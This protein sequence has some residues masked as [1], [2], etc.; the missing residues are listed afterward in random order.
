MTTQ[1]LD[2]QAICLEEVYLYAR[3]VAYSFNLSKEQVEDHVQ[4][5]VIKVYEKIG[6]LKD[7]SKLSSW[8]GM[9]T[10]NQCLGG[11]RSKFY[12]N[13]R[14][15]SNLSSNSDSNSASISEFLEAP[16]FEESYKRERQ[17]DYV[18]NWI[19]SMPEGVRKNIVAMFYLESRSV[20]Q[21]S[22]ELEI[23]SSTVLSHLRRF[24]LSLGESFS[25][26]FDEYVNHIH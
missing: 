3:K 18:R 7:P 6:Q 1:T 25:S 10:R 23:K 22:S 24:R 4:E 21:I 20:T 26:G 11:F 8:V 12:K 17:V 5:V 13:E 15:F 14:S 16:S 19:L 9:I 2:S